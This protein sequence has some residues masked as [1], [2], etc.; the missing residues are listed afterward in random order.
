MKWGNGL[1]GAMVLTEKP[2]AS[3]K[4]ILT[5]EFQQQLSDWYLENISV[6]EI[7][8]RSYNELLFKMKVTNNSIIV[9]KDN[10]LFSKDYVEGFYKYVQLPGV[11]TTY[12]EYAIKIADIQRK[13]EEKGKKFIYIISP[14][15][16][17]IYPE[18]I[19]NKYRYMENTDRITN[20]NRELNEFKVNGINYYDAWAD[21]LLI[22]EQIPA[23]YRQGIHWSYA[24]CA[25]CLDSAFN[26]YLTEYSMET[27]FEKAEMPS[28]ADRDLYSLANIW[29]KPYEDDYYSANVYWNIEEKPNIFILGTS[30][31]DQIV[32]VLKGTFSDEKLFEE[33]IHYSYLNIGYKINENG[34]ESIPLSLNL[35]DTSILQDIQ[36]SDIVIFENNATY[37]PDSYFIVADYL[38]EH[39]K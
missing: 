19:P 13:L 15:K 5:G 38:Y 4:S 23:F 11:E 31:S 22:K 29:E 3:F 32:E 24:S 27:E 14:S 20:H 9:G 17:E 2:I 10:Y 6:Y 34:M 28:G 30:F 21:M 33:L 18:F 16:A 12:P 39:L 36:N 8:V 1:Y 7:L 25:Y 35:D 37:I 26:E